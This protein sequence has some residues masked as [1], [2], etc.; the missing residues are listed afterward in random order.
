MSMPIDI[1]WTD[2]AKFSYFEE[3]DFIDKK[4]TLKEVENFIVLV[5]DFIKQLSSRVIQGK[6]YTNNDIYSVVISKQTTVFYR[7]YPKQNSIALLL[8][9]NNQK[10]QNSLKR[11][12]KQV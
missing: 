5:E 6:F 9:W 11:L 7:R 12:L 3:L 2:Y 4:W 8:F 1:T 10:N